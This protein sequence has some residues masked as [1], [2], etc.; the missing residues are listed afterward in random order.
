MSKA[1]GFYL[2]LGD[3]LFP[4]AQTPFKKGD[5]VLMIEDYGLCRHFKYHKN[6]I[7]FFLIAMREYRDE[8]MKKGVKVDYY[9]ADH[10]LFKKSYAEKVKDF[11]KKNK[12]LQQIHLYEVSDHFFADDLAKISKDNKLEL[13]T[14]DNP[15]FLTPKEEFANY[16]DQSKKPFM[17]TFYSRQRQRL[18]VLVNKKGEPEGGR[19]SFDTENRKK[20]PKGIT[21]PVLPQVKPSKH[22]PDVE[23]VVEKHFKQHPG[24]TDHFWLPTTRS[25]SL[26]WLD[27]FIEE[28]FAE[29]G[30]YEDAI[31]AEDTFGF[32]SVISPML[33]NG[34]LTPAE[35]V[36]KIVEKGKKQKVSLASIEGYVRQVI[37]WREFV[38]GIYD[39][40]SEKMDKDNYWDHHR[41]M[42][43]C[44]Y[45]G[46]TGVAPLDDSIG[47]ARK[48][49]YTHHI[50]RL[51]VLSNLMLL[52]EIDP[53]QVH[54][55]FMEMYVDSADWVM[56][57]NVYGMGQMS[58]GGIFSTKPYICG[59]NYIRKMSDYKKND[60]CDT[61]DGLYWRFIDKNKKSFASNPRMSMMVRMLDKVD[62]KRKKLIF[63]KAEDFI[64]ETT[65]KG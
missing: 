56:A 15:M 45:T 22:F 35:V 41:K 7:L 65:N 50:E 52:C 46:N 58:E 2:V 18:G 1:K 48:Y 13:V 39:H 21:I 57:A 8:L 51:M 12:G 62:K 64:E 59:S 24:D 11:C 30:P 23:K 53:R 17:A 63:K 31:K 4:M 27:C 44:W 6:K 16:L 33:N 36:E 28:R 19:W 38:K 42:K 25:Q 43:S 26:K 37:G 3:Q 47:K 5:H 32:H 20:Y 10:D 60:W 55:W 61:V 14:H 40:Y 29:F 49:G 54:R 34:L 9:S